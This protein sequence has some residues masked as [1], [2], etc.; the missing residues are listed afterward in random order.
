[1]ISKYNEYPQLSNKLRNTDFVVEANS[2]ERLQ[3]WKEFSKEAQEQE[4]VRPRP[5]F[6][7]EQESYGFMVDVGEVNGMP[8]VLSGFFALINE[9]RIMFYNATSRMVDHR[10]VDAWL[11]ENCDPMY[12]GGS[13]KARTD[14]M[15]F[16][17]VVSML[18]EQK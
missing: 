1:M 3:L 5:R 10:M 18:E 17:H 12:C 16:G 4:D 7:W 13:R 11:D 15:N 9:R 6:K 8:V 2:Y 14:A